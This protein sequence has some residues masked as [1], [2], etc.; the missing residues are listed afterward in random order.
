[1]P[2]VSDVYSLLPDRPDNAET[3]DAVEIEAILQDLSVGINYAINTS[4]GQT[5]DFLNMV[6]VPT[7]LGGYGITDAQPLEPTLT[8]LAAV[9]FAADTGLYATAADTFAT[10]TQTAFARTLLDDATA[11]AARATLELVITTTAEYRNNTPDRILTTD[12]VWAAGAMVTL[13]D[14]ASIVVDF[15]TFINA[16]VTLAGNRTLA[17]G[18]NKK[19][20][21]TGHFEVIQDATGSRTLAYGSEY[22]FAGG[23]EPILTTTPLASDLLFYKIL[24]ATRVFI[25]PSL[26]VKV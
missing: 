7:T 5:V 2:V 26:D 15:D 22:E 19:V 6:N 12:Q 25:S 24:S 20:G 3:A 4:L 8:A 1:M 17:N 13:T 14:A 11:L 16:D 10:Y 21:Q 18:T 9:T 23:I